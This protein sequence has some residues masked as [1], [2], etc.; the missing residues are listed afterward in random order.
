MESSHLMISSSNCE[1]FFFYSSVWRGF[2]DVNERLKDFLA[3][4][5][6][7]RSFFAILQVSVQVDVFFLVRWFVIKYLQWVCGRHRALSGH[8]LNC[9]RSRATSRSPTT[10]PVCTSK[11]LRRRRYCCCTDWQALRSSPLSCWSTTYTSS[12]L[13][14]WPPPF[15]SITVPISFDWNIH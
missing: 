15:N 9:W 8:Q 11:Y 3:G 4:H 1:R 13:E 5:Q 7:K 12:P 6:S 14:G 2:F 10:P